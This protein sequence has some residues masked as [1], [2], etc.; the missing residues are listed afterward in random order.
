[1]SC[2]RS[3]SDRA[4]PLSSL[5]NDTDKL[6]A[7]LAHQNKHIS[8][9]ILMSAMVFEPFPSQ[10]LHLPICANALLLPSIGQLTLSSRH[11]SRH[12]NHGPWERF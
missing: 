10:D 5:S 1:M 8:I 4:S 2:G 11:L 6:R 3:R 9:P 7:H 12:R